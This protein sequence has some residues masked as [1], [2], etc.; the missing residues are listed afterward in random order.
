MGLIKDHHLRRQNEY[1]QPVDA[2]MG[3]KAPGIAV[4]H[5]ENQQQE[6]DGQY[7]KEGPLFNHLYKSLSTFLFTFV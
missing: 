7:E 6:K 1:G 5:G 2:V 4:P 3:K